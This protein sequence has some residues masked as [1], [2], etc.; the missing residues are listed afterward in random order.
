MISW[1]KEFISTASFSISL[2]G[3]LQG[4]S[5][6]KRGLRQGEPISPYLFVLAMEYLSRSLKDA[7]SIHTFKYHPK[8]DKIGFTHLSFADDIILF[9]RGNVQS[10]TILINTL[11]QFVRSYGLEIN[12]TKSSL[13]TTGV[14]EE[15]LQN[16]LLAT[17]F[18]AGSFPMRYL[19][20]PLVFGKA[21]SCYFNPLIN[22]ITDFLKAW[23]T[24]SLSYAGRLELLKTVIRG[25]ESF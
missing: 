8:C 19:G 24:H 12:L 6:C 9:S 1:I 20:T 2:N 21:K 4:F 16:L 13:F 23:S 7:T 11:R 17:G 18:S 14:T 15:E 22:R 10:V 25:V 3:K 5:N